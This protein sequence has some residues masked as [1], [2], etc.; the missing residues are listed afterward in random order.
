YVCEDLCLSVDLQIDSINNRFAIKKDFHTKPAF[1]VDTR[2]CPSYFL[3]S[4]DLASASPRLGP[5]L[6]RLLLPLNVGLA[7]QRA[8]VAIGTARLIEKPNDDRRPD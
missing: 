8:L 6:V 5:F 3:P 4:A 7:C 2:K 1:P